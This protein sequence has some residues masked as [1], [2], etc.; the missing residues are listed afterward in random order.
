MRLNMV[1]RRGGMGH[2]REVSFQGLERLGLAPE[3]AVELDDRRNAQVELARYQH[4]LPIACRIAA[5]A[6]HDL[7][8]GKLRTAGKS[9][10]RNAPFR[11]NVTS[12]RFV[13]FIVIG[14]SRE[15]GHVPEIA[16]VER[17]PVS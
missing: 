4:G 9:P 1:A 2:R 15:L 12:Q 8:D 11:K 6:Q 3:L 5:T 10:A 14:P 16:L 17:E 13:V 7:F